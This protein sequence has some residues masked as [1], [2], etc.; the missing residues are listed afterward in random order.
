[1]VS[2]AYYSAQ[3]CKPQAKLNSELFSPLYFSIKLGYNSAYDYVS[4]QKTDDGDS[5][6]DEPTD[7]F[8]GPERRSSNQGGAGGGNAAPPTPPPRPDPVAHRLEMLSTPRESDNFSP[9]IVECLPPE[10]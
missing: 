8:S 10:G 2:V 6:N 3:T 7:L 5:G 4:L 1:M 9:R